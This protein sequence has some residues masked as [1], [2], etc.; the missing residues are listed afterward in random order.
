M[1]TVRSNGRGFNVS[2]FLFGNQRDSV[3]WNALNNNASILSLRVGPI[4]ATT[5]YFGLRVP[6]GKVFVLYDRVLTVSEG[7]YNVDVCEDSGAFTTAGATELTRHPIDEASEGDFECQVWGNVT[8]GGSVTVEEFGFI[9]TGTNVGSARAGGASGTE[10]LVKRFT[11][12]SLLRIQNADA[13]T[14][15]Y[16][17][18]LRLVAWEEDI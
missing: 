2:D 3:G 13:G 16:T 15:N 12:D 6:E 8:P 11:G 4:S 10:Q 17:V 5:Y 18:V 9:D 14:N 7:L 1:R